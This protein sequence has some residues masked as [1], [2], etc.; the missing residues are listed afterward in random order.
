VNLSSKTMVWK[1]GSK[2]ITVIF[3]GDKVVS[4]AQSG[5]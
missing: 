2:Q 5:L 3:S 4:K 1:D